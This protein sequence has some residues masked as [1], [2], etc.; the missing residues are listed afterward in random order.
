MKFRLILAFIP[1]ALAACDE[2]A[3]AGLNLPFGQKQPEVAAPPVP[4]ANPQAPSVSPLQ[5]PIEIA[6]AETRQVSTAELQT[7]N[8]AAFTASGNEPFWRVD[9]A[10]GK[11][12]YRTPDNQKGRVIAVRRIIYAGGVEYIGEYNA[13][14]FALNIHTRQCEDSMSGEKFPMVATLGISGKRNSGCARPAEAAPA[15]S[16]S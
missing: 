7:M 14:P 2:N 4:P 12:L 10:D 11:A 15:A 1:L 16:A 9:V 5:Q 3:M 6:G 13:R 8:T